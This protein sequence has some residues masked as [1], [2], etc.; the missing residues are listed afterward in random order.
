MLSDFGF[1]EAEK[2]ERNKEE[3]LVGAFLR[4]TWCC[5]LSSLFRLL[6]TFIKIT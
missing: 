2:G 4:D 6:F 3:S 5:P 1:P